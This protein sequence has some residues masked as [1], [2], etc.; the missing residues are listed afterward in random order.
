MGA[1]PCAASW[2]DSHSATRQGEPAEGVA[3]WQN[4]RMA[5][6]Q[7]GRM[8]EWQNGRMARPRIIEIRA[9]TV[10]YQRIRYGC[11]MSDVGYWM[12]EHRYVMRVT[13]G[14][15]REAITPFPVMARFSVPACRCLQL[16]QQ[17]QRNFQALSGPS[18][19][20][21]GSHKVLFCHESFV[22][23]VSL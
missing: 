22:I 19:Q 11:R 23:R 13:G 16:V 1:T 15:K 2:T 17:L 10:E 6:W 9:L 7:N 21:F 20:L 5:E 4:G 18:G 12:F 3:E 14:N 8:A